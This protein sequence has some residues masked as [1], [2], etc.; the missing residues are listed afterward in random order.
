MNENITIKVHRCLEKIPQQ[1]WDELANL[2]GNPFLL[3]TFLSDLEK[4][5]S[6]CVETGWSPHHLAVYDENNCLVGMMPLYL[7]NHS[8]GEYVFDHAWAQAFEHAGGHY[9][10]KL[11]SGIPFTPVTGERC[12]GK[13]RHIL[14]HEAIKI[15]QDYGV[16][17]LHILFCTKEEWDTAPNSFLRRRDQQFHWENQS[18]QT[19]DDFLTTLTSRKRKTIKKERIQATANDVEIHTLT[20]NSIEPAHWDAFWLFYQDTGARKWGQPYITRQM[21]DCLHKNMR[22][23]I[24]LILAMRQGKWIAGA[25]NFI[26]R[27]TLYGRYWGCLEDH[28]YLHFEVCYYRAIDFAIKHGF[29]RVEAGA[30]GAHKIARGYMPH[31]TY[32]LH[33]IANA[34]FKNAIA[35]Y[36]EQ[37]RDYVE[38]D[39]ITLNSIAPYKKL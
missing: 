4:S 27:D 11:V 2:S 9:Y 7:K 35:H 23:K 1:S 24:L 17:S 12:L 3:H 28:P 5:E 34:S 22:D 14:W 38:Q 29:K 8:Q 15:A 31:A 25:L 20:G 18:Y 30:Q 26:G 21:F 36:L 13:Y 19:F 33:W 37:E 10:P 6:V 32:S 39:M 16:S